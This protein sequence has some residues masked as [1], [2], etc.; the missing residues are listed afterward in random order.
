VCRCFVCV[1]CC[2]GLAVS[3]VVHMTLCVCRCV[4][5][6]ALSIS[7]KATE[8]IPTQPRTFVKPHCDSGRTLAEIT[9]S[10][11]FIIFAVTILA[12]TNTVLQID[13][14]LGECR[15]QSLLASPSLSLLIPLLLLPNRFIPRQLSQCRR[16]LFFETGT[17]SASSQPP[18][19][20]PCLE[21][22]L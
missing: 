21:H 6:L 19:T 18:T 22:Q 8:I 2:S 14:S 10:Q 3:R 11:S 1:S 17:T 4:C 7:H 12:I 9:S 13:V 16:S 5:S 20:L 15:Q